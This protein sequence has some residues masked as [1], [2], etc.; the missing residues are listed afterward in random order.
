M[1]V[2]KLLRPGDRRTRSILLSA[3][4]T[5]AWTEPSLHV[6]LPGVF[7]AENDVK[8]QTRMVSRMRSTRFITP[9]FR[10]CFALPYSTYDALTT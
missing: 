5:C 6:K 7:W 1:E 4:E 2:G 10:I 3:S 8:L 9:T